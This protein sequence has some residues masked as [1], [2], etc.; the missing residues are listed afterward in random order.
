VKLFK[1]AAQAVHIVPIQGWQVFRIGTDPKFF[2]D[3]SK[4]FEVAYADAK[5][6]KLPVVIHDPGPG[7]SLMV[8]PVPNKPVFGELCPACKHPTIIAVDDSGYFCETP[9]CSRNRGEQLLKELF[10]DEL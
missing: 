9:G 6:R 10:C 7:Q 2:T 8:T 4:A 1:K 5:K 3:K